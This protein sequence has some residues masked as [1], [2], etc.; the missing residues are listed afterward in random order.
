[1]I[2][3]CNAGRDNLLCNAGRDKLALKQCTMYLEFDELLLFNSPWVPCKFVK[4]L[5]SF[6]VE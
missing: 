1:M 2:L 5:S 6:I 4:L 3:L